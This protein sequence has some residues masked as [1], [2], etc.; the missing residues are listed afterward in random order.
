MKIGITGPI[1]A[2]KSTVSSL[3]GRFSDV[4]VIDAD[5][6]AHELVAAQT[7]LARRI[8]AA[9]GDPS[10]AGPNG[11]DRKRTAEIVF[12]D[13]E[14][15]AI[16]DRLIRPPLVFELRN[17]MAASRRTH[18]ILDAALLFD[19]PIKDELDGI[20]LVWAD[21]KI[22]LRRLMEKGKDETGA[23]RRMERQGDWTERR[24]K[25]DWTITNNGS[26]Q[27]LERKVRAWW[28][29]LLIGKGLSAPFPIR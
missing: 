24:S 28:D 10:L 26:P 11:L 5:T 17:R 18:R 22:R 15:L 14:K 27:E 9:L 13:A 6:V 20:L 4:D 23:R 3:V 21:P 12:A 7:D 2:G 29:A 19:W 8:A 16:L 25:A 1:A